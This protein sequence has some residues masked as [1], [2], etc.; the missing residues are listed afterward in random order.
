[1]T[2]DDPT[3]IPPLED[4]KSGV[5]RPRPGTILLVE[6]SPEDYEPLFVDLPRPASPFPSSAV[7]TATTRLT[8]CIAG[9]DMRRTEIR[10]HGR[11]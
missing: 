1:M 7:S 8:T 10:L 3:R 11:D 9:R 6:D 4:G 2:K 5:A